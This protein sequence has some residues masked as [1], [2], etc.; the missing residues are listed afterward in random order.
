[1]AKR[2]LYHSLFDFPNQNDFISPS[3]SGSR[4]S[5]SCIN[6]LLSITHEMYHSMD[7]GYAIQ[8]VFL[9]ILKASDKVWHEGLVFK[10]K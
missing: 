1:M 7:E 4:P 10:L 6:Q 9:D 3:Q 5:D 8:G 2:I